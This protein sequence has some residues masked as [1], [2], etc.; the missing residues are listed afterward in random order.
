MNSGSR[1]LLHEGPSNKVI[2]RN[3]VF[4]FLNTGCKLIT[5]S[6]VHLVQDMAMNQDS[7]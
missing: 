3:Q 1:E 5:D 7:N 6:P 2:I 4:I